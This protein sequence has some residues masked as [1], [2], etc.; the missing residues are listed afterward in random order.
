MRMI[1]ADRSTG[2][3][4][5]DRDVGQW[6]L[7]LNCLGWGRLNMGE[8]YGNLDSAR[9]SPKGGS[10]LGLLFGFSPTETTFL[11]PWQFAPRE[12]ESRSSRREDSPNH[13]NGAMETINMI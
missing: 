3:R 4:R 5:L 6:S 2:S 1:E 8:D 11:H 10:L 12:L 9:G 7:K 13:P